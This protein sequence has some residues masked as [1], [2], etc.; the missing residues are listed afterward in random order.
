[1]K[2]TL[3]F[4]LGKSSLN[5][6]IYHEKEFIPA[7]EKYLKL[8]D[9]AF[10]TFGYNKESMAT[11]QISKII[12]VATGYGLLTDGT[13]KINIRWLEDVPE[14]KKNKDKI[15]EDA[16]LSSNCIGELN[17]DKSVTVQSLL[18][19]FVADEE[20]DEDGTRRDA[21]PA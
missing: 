13:V 4:K 18:F 6:R 11:L 10:V 8:G 21:P 16:E 12:G 1:M 2:L 19:L 3:N 14:Y 9:R 5:G 7:L 17:A 20:G 15:N